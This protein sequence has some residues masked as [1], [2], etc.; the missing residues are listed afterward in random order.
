[1]EIIRSS[2]ARCIFENARFPYI[3][4]RKS[5]QE[6]NTRLKIQTLE[7]KCEICSK[8]TIK[9]GIFIANFEHI[10]C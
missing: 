9:T 10:S 7:K 4:L 3:L 6:T 1:M 5:D 8:L 2:R